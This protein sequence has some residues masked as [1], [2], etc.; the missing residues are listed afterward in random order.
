MIGSALNFPRLVLIL[1]NRQT[2]QDPVVQ[3]GCKIKSE[4]MR[5]NAVPFTAQGTKASS[6]VFAIVVSSKC[7]KIYF[8]RNNCVLGIN[9]ESGSW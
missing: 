9:L 6:L 3:H 8:F 5:G 2:T 1:K 4:W 7:G